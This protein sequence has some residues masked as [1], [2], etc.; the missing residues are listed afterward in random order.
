L[1]VTRGSS[2]WSDAAFAAAFLLTLVLFYRV[3]APFLM[4]VLV[5]LFIVVL[6]GGA[7]ERL[8][9]R[10]RGRRRLAASISTSVVLLAV[11][12]PAA[13][14]GYLLVLE[15]AELL[16]R[17][18]DFLGPGGLEELVR[19]RVPWRLEPLFDRLDELGLGARLAEA[20]S[21]GATWLTGQVGE[22]VG[23]TAAVTVDAF[24][25]VV[26]IFY[27]F[28]D[29]PRLVVKAMRLS[30]LENR[31][32]REFFREFRN[33]SYAMVYVNVV[34]ALAQGLLGALG[35]VLVG[36]SQPLVWAGMMAFFSFV[37]LLGTGLVWV[38]A[39]VLLA[40]NGRPLAG[41]FLAGWGLLVIGSVDNVLRPLLAKGRMQLH[42]LLVFL[43]LFGGLTAFGPIGLLVGPLIG[44][45]FTAMLRIWQRDFV[46]R[47]TP[48]HRRS[49][50]PRPPSV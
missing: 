27:F 4:P 50:Q 23:A 6:F 38:P 42:P 34:T 40:L 16:R 8:V 25:T 46:P 31:Y 9:R 20:A 13:V 3:V 14:V 30:P 5:G 35:F 44:S 21:A 17:I 32:E 18:G 47:L 36:I 22:V 29:G 24:L 43:T 37:P 15:G 2:R 1:V 19:G 33:V 10:L 28:V 26:T 11:L 7:N 39:S 49:V 12:A 45:L 41:L 48:E